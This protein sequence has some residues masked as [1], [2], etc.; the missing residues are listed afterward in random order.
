VKAHLQSTALSYVTFF[1]KSDKLIEAVISHLHLNTLEEDIPD[2]L[3]CLGFDVISVKQKSL[4][5][6]SL[7][8]GTTTIPCA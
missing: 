8:E 3:V 1:Y 4:T 5:Y 2:E 6:R 7:A